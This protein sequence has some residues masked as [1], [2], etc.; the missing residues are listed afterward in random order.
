MGGVVINSQPVRILGASAVAASLTGT[1]TE[2]TLATVP[3]AAGVMGL[4]GI[5]RV[6]TLWTVTNSANNK[7]LFVKL[8]GAGGTGYFSRVVTAVASV[9]NCTLIRNRNSQA[10]QIAFFNGGGASGGWG[11]N[12]SA[13]TT[14][15]I[16]TATA[17]DLVIR[18]QLA[19]VGE[20]IT[21]ESYLVELIT[22]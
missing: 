15:T 16:N 11:D 14:G 5:L 20:T 6:T 13:N 21:L 12:G 7:T 1:L 8:G 19:N 3:I 18:G 2:T 9:S 17:Q 4:N 22:P 10:S